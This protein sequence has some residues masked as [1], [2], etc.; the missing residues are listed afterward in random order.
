MLRRSLLGSLVVVMLASA[1]LLVACAAHPA[2]PGL[3]GQGAVGEVD[4][5]ASSAAADAWVVVSFEDR[6]DQFD[7][8][9]MDALFDTEMAADQALAEADAGWID[10]NDVG[11]HGYELY[12]VG[13]DPKEIWAAIQ[14]VFASAPVPWTR[15]ELRQGFEDPSPLVLTNDLPR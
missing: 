13:E 2:S 11:D 15:V 9:L 3:N 14:P 1:G 8:N 12:F 7:Q 6:D 4:L 10:G 5:D